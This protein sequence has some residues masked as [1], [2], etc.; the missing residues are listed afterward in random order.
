MTPGWRQAIQD[1]EHPGLLLDRFTPAEAFETGGKRDWLAHIGPTP[2]KSKDEK[3]RTVLNRKLLDAQ[4][5]RWVET[6]AQAFV[7]ASFHH[8]TAVE[9]AARTES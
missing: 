2:P 5:A 8:L 1:C 9:A 3:P 6:A 4:R 7:E